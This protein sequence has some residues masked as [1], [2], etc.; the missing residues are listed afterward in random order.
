MRRLIQAKPAR[1]NPR[2]ESDAALMRPTSPVVST[3]KHFAILAATPNI[4]S[5]RRKSDRRANAT[6]IVLLPL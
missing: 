2:P 1:D 6:K 4:A 5:R 3:K